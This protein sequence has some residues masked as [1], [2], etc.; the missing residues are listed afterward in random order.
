MYEVRPILYA[1]MQGRDEGMQAPAVNAIHA[2]D[3]I[4]GMKRMADGSVDIIVTSPPYNIGKEYA[5]HNDRMPREQYLAWMG[6]VAGEARRV[7]K[8]DGSF[9][10]NIGGK[11]SDP[12]IPFDVMQEFRNRFALQ[13]VIH[14]IKSSWK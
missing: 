7:L 11:P 2:C 12:W 6:E 4:A 5:T 1:T 14:W 3:C 9:F 10:L 13:N 8:D